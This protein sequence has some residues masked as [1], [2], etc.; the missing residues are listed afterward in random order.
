MRGGTWTSHAGSYLPGYAE[1]QLNAPPFCGYMRVSLTRSII[2]HSLEESAWPSHN[3]SPRFPSNGSRRQKLPFSTET[4]SARCFVICHQMDDLSS[5]IERCCYCSTTRAH[6]S[7]RSR[8]SASTTWISAHSRA[9]GCTA[10]WQSRQR[11]R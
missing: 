3:R 8:T 5:A 1:H 2:D 6:E 7:K 4:K 9:S 10:K 11:Q